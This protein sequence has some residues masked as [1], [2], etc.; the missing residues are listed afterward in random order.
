[1]VRIQREVGQIARY[2]IDMGGDI[3][4]FETAMRVPP[5]ERLRTL[6]VEEL[7]RM[8]LHTADSAFSVAI[9]SLP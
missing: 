9:T 2:I 6:T 1:M 3:E 4:L 5:W 8:R 7:I